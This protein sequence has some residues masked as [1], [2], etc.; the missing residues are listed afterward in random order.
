MTAPRVLLLSAELIDY[1]DADTPLLA[2]A[3]AGRGI[4]ATVV[5]WRHAPQHSADLAVIRSTWDYTLHR[6]AFLDSLSRLT[7]PMLN[8]LDVVRWN[9]HKGYLVELADAGV[10]VVPTSLVPHASTPTLP[11]LDRPFV[12]KPAVSA[13][14]WGA[15]RFSPGQTGANRHLTTLLADGDVLVQPLIDLSEQGERSLLYLGGVY[16]HTIRKVPAAGDFRVQVNHGGVEQTDA[17]T[18]HELAVAAR[19]LAAVPYPDDLLY[20]RVD[21]VGDRDAPLLMELELI[22]PQLFLDRVDGA[23]DRLADAVL[24]ALG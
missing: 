17:A 15:E 16:S 21:L 2:A 19:A 10:P 8:P 24:R 14:A 13:S 12:I 4:E 9:S 20:A 11:D 23:A 7:A 3:L 22:E 18:E 5:D 1:P 6:D